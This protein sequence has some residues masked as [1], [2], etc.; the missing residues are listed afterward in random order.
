METWISLGLGVIGFSWV[1]LRE[2]K[3]IR[4]QISNILDVHFISPAPV[5]GVS[6]VGATGRPYFD[7]R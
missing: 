2:L 5:S 4:H 6:P 3:A 1:M 7:W